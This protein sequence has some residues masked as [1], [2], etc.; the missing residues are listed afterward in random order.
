MIARIEGIRTKMT[1]PQSDALAQIRGAIETH[2]NVPGLEG[3]RKKVTQSEAELEALITRVLSSNEHSEA[4][5]DIKA[6]FPN[7]EKNAAN[8]ARF[9]NRRAVLAYWLAMETW[10]SPKFNKYM[11]RDVRDI[12]GDAFVVDKRAEIFLP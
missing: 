9:I 11:T 4:Y 7:A 12:L 2:R 6:L 5:Q 8:A 1:L 3:R 10:R